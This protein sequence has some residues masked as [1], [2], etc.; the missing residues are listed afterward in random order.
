MIRG[1]KPKM[2][3]GK[4]PHARRKSLQKVGVSTH[5]TK[6]KWT[7]D[8]PERVYRLALLGCTDNEMAKILGIS[9]DTITSWKM[10]VPEFLDAI[11]CG[12]GEADSKVA[13]SMYKAACGYE[14][15]EKKYYRTKKGT[16]VLSE[17]TVKHVQPN[18]TAQI[19]WLKNRTRHLE[20]NWTDVSRMEHTGKDGIPLQDLTK[21]QEETAQLTTEELTLLNSISGKLLTNKPQA[22][23]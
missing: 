13:H 4:T 20:N 9:P 23:A 15:E 18:T 7:P 5:S 1:D 14:F 21:K 2:K 12:R 3:R 10:K 8:M 11:R 16:M 17:K 19:F 6:T 22:E